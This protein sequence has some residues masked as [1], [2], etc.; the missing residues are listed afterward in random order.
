METGTDCMEVLK[1]RAE[2]TTKY[3]TVGSLPDESGAT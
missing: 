3:F 2:N 1:L